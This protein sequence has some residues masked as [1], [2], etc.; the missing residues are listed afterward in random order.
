MSSEPELEQLEKLKKESQDSIKR[1]REMAQ[2][3][4]E[5]EGSEAYEP[6]LF[7]PTD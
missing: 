3:E 5:R 6:P 4:D 7:Q 1:A 2:A